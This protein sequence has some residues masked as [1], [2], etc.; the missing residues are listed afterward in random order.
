MSGIVEGKK[1]I[2]LFLPSLGSHDLKAPK[3]SDHVSPT[4]AA[5]LLLEC[6]VISLYEDR[7][8]FLEF[9]DAAVKFTPLGPHILNQFRRTRSMA[10]PADHPASSVAEPH[11]R[12]QAPPGGDL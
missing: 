12:S 11:I 2:D 6:V 3:K 9:L 5:Q 7:E 1:L 8:F 4:R 10:E